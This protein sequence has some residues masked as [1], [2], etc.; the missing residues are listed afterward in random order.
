MQNDESSSPF[1]PD[2]A[3]R[4]ELL[5]LEAGD[6]L[7]IEATFASIEVRP[8]DDDARPRIELRGRYADAASIRVARDAGVVHVSVDPTA[9]HVGGMIF[10]QRHHPVRLV[11]YVPRRGLRGQLV[12]SA[13]RLSVVRLDEVDLEITADAGA[14]D[15][16]D[17]SGELRLTT[18]AGKIDGRGVS[19][20]VEATTDAG[21]IRLEIAHLAPGRH[22]VST[23]VGSVRIDLARGM[24]VQI[25]AHTTMGSSRV[26]VR[27]TPGAAAQLEVNAELGSVR[28]RESSRFYEAALRAPIE[29]SAPPPAE[30][31]FRTAQRG[32][33]HDGTL[34][35]VL[36][37]VASGELDA[38]AAADLLRAL[39]NG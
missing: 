16:E 24:P 8:V 3:H 23:S 11:A 26:D 13:G 14:I 12:T 4:A 36:A 33:L 31:P 27:S 28:V 20:R 29:V 1:S 30:G 21:S 34:D 32:P 2:E 35:R 37:R 6:A 15:L 38:R 18:S 22:V 39:E 17:V 25:G 5:P 19:G 7:E 10:G 9:S